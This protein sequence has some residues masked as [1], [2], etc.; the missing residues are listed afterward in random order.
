MPFKVTF[1]DYSADE[2]MQIAQMEADKRGFTISA[3]AEE[4]VRACCE[5]ASGNENAGNGRFCRNLVEDS[6]LNFA[7]RVYGQDDA[8]AEQG[9]MLAAEDFVL[10]AVLQGSEKTEERTIGFKCS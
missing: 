9:F 7:E 4:H 1:P 3:D 2:L 6:I 8:P 10:P 5:S